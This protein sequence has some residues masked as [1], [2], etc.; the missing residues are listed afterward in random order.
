MAAN[1][2][3]IEELFEVPFAVEMSGVAEAAVL[4][5]KKPKN[6]RLE[7]RFPALMRAHQDH[8]WLDSLIA[9]QVSLSAVHTLGVRN[10]QDF[11]K[12][13]RA[14]SIIRDDS[15]YINLMSYYQT[16]AVSARY[17]SAF[18]ERLDT[19]IVDLLV[20]ISRRYYGLYK[21]C[22]RVALAPLADNGL[23]YHLS[24]FSIAQ[25]AVVFWKNNTLSSNEKHLRTQLKFPGFDFVV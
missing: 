25:K 4:N 10:L 1:D 3:P 2:W 19:I 8:V 5:N 23:S 22:G 6:R 17:D 16:E 20:S 21:R 15:L 18:T 13:D 14:I 11:F 7:N 24:S 9:M 12:V